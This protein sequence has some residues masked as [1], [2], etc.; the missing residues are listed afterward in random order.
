M[1]IPGPPVSLKCVRARIR[2]GLSFGDLPSAKLCEGTACIMDKIT[3][4]HDR[5]TQGDYGALLLWHYVHQLP[6]P[7]VQRGHLL[8]R[9]MDGGATYQA[10]YDD[11]SPAWL[12]TT[13]VTGDPLL[14]QVEVFRSHDTQP[15]NYV[16]LLH[17]AASP[18]QAVAVAMPGAPSG[19]FETIP[20]GPL[21][22]ATKRSLSASLRAVLLNP[23]HRQGNPM[24][25]LLWI[26][27]ALSFVTADTIPDVVATLLPLCAD[28]TEKCGLRL[29]GAAMYELYLVDSFTPRSTEALSRAVQDYRQTRRNLLQ[30]TEDG[31]HSVSVL[32][33]QL[34]E[35]PGRVTVRVGGEG[36]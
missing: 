13:V 16:L 9:F 7:W 10:T 32:V 4:H 8:V 18:L 6:N 26:H 15:V 34:E 25:G 23:G 17:Q 14:V 21:L 24:D 27:G 22:Y 30:R 35:E 3:N 31:I 33:K 20:W 2:Q 5:R 28:G 19:L 1:A 12:A 36:V 11:L 29:V